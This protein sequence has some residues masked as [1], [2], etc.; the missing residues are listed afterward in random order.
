MLKQ[1]GFLL[2]Q[3]LDP[4]AGYGGLSSTGV[5]SLRPVDTMK[6]LNNKTYKPNAIHHHAQALVVSS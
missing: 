6:S 2:L 5:H 3:R 4:L 1:W